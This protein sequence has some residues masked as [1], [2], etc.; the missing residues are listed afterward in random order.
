MPG[1]LKYADV[2]LKKGVFTD[3]NEFYNWI[4]GISLNTYQ[5]LTVVIR[6]LN[7]EGE[8]EVTWQLNNAFP[9]QVTPTDLNS[10]A[11]EAAIETIVFAHEGLEVV[12]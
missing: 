3:D 8:P 9:L 7:E 2:T 10:T 12:L 4:S 6:L 5:R 1:M 11:S